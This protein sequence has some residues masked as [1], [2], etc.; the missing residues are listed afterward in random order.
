M[1]DLFLKV[2]AVAEKKFGG[3][4]TIFKFTTHYKGMFGTIDVDALTG[5][6]QIR[7][8]PGFMTLQ[9]ALSWMLK[10][11]V[12]PDHFDINRIVL[13]V[14]IGVLAETLDEQQDS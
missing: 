5:R 12:G 14:R 8:L 1:E 13:G 11:Q 9:E 2:R 4:F 7:D 6:Q 3:H 10:N